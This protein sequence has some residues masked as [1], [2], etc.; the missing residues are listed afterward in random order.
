MQQGLGRARLLRLRRARGRRASRSSTCRSSERREL[1]AELLDRRSRTVRLSET[2]DDGEALLEAA[3]AQGLEGVDGEAGRLAATSRAARAS[4][5]KVK[6]P[7][8]AGVRRRRLHEGPGPP[9]AP[10]RA[11]ARRSTRTAGCA[12]SATS[13]RASRNARLDE[14]L[15]RLRPLERPTRRS[16]RCR[17]C[18]ASARATSSGSSRS[19]SSEVRVRRVDARRAPARPVVPRPARRQ[20]CREEVRREAPAA[21]PE[22]RESAR[23]SACSS[24]PTSTRSS[25]PR[26]GSRRATCS[27]TTATI[28]PVL[29]PHLK[30]RPF[31]M[32]RYPD[33][34]QGELLLPEG[35]AEAHARLDPDARPTA[36]RRASRAQKRMISY[37]LVNDE[38]ALLVDGE[39]GL[40]RHERVV[41][42]RRP[43]RAARLRALRP[44]P[45]A[46]R[47]LPGD[48]RGRAARQG[49]AGRARA[50]RASRR[51]AG[52]TASTCSCRSSG[53]AT[54]ADT[55]EFAEIVAARARSTHRGLVTT[56]WPKAKRRGVL[57][58]ANQNGEGKTIASVYS[59]RPQGR[60]RRCRRRCAGTRSTRRSTPPRSRWRSCSSGSR[61]TATCSR[62][63]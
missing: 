61:S 53:A 6:V 11:R 54:Y 12:G 5:V 52:P 46:G 3:R 25:G 20:A 4:W 57:I 7:A 8:A 1:L 24:C 41:L 48:G 34:W 29:V 26:R 39:H 55:R 63:C 23:A 16:R 2:F 32:K 33:G 59:V 30:D 19:S 27:R 18:R 58:D 21:E 45:L 50:R 56:E 62:A 47:R 43:A 14:L 10:R 35:R 37:P 60:A 9:D 17:R 13:A 28:A 36:R 44:R 51:R 22:I 15:D 40:H 42:A 49:G 38:L 31:T